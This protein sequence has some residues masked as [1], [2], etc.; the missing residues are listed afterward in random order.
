MVKKKKERVRRTCGNC[1][2]SGRVNCTTCNTHGHLVHYLQLTVQYQDHNNNYV[3]ETTD[4]PDELILS[5]SGDV[6]MN[7]HAFRVGEI[8]NFH[9]NV[10]NTCTTI[11]NS[12]NRK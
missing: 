1:H 2:G 12:V 5:A 4:L 11:N 10:S 6:L 3:Y 9:I 7:E 8:V